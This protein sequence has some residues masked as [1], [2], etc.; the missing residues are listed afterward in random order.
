M[1]HLAGRIN[2]SRVEDSKRLNKIIKRVKSDRVSLKFQS[3]GKNLEINV[4]MDASFGNLHDAGS[5]GGHFIIT[6][7]DHQE[8]NSISWQSCK[9]KRVVK[10][11]LASETLAL[12]GGIDNACSISI[13]LVELLNNDHQKTIP[14]KCFVDNN[15]LVKVIK[16]TKLVADKRLRTEIASIKEMLDKGEI[17]SITWLKSN[18]QTV[19]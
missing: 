15:D 9:I 4:L 14:I 2:T 6:K 18:N 10:S 5:Q 11:M 7:R 12:S 16:S 1:R 17:C 19:N 8:K 13:L 3:L